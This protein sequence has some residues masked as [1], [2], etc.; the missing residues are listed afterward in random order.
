MLES[1]VTSSNLAMVAKRLEGDLRSRGLQQGDR[2]LTVA[3]AALMLG[4]SN[5]TAH[6][7]MSILVRKKLLTRQHGRGTFV[8]E[9][10]GQ[11]RAARV[12]TV[13]ILMPE[14]DRDVSSV[15]LEDMMDSLRAR[16]GGVNVQFSFIPSSNSVDYVRELIG[17]AQRIGQFAGAVPISCPRA[18]YKY[19]EEIGGPMVVLGSLYADQRSL[20]S[21]DVDYR[22]IGQL[23]ARYLVKKGHKRM[24]LLLT[25][26][27]RPGDNAFYDGI[28]DALTEA[29]LPHNALTVRIYPHDFEAFRAQVR[30]LLERP[31]RPTGIICGTDRLVGIVESV[32]SSLELRIGRD[33]ELVF[34]GQSTPAVER[35]PYVHAQP[36][37]TFKQIANTVADMLRTLS[38]GGAL[39]Q[40][41][42]IVP[43][44]LREPEA[45]R[46]GRG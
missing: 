32:A 26:E 14:A 44:E 8:G 41:R 21:V 17:S 37:L 25:G 29:D 16:L 7:A 20:A 18:V 42:V 3:D 11:K 2:Y 28:S 30:E 15:Q 43:V 9:G 33:V 13:Y 27:G 39:E 6:R 24:A 31:D 46:S 36:Q 12:R 22:Q 5:A 19:L 4:V 45:G 38:E 40:D 34:Q 10:I 1:P 23:L 35:L